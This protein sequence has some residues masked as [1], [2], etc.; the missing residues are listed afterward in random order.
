MKL[1]IL[2]S[3]VI[4]SALR[5]KHIP[6]EMITLSEHLPDQCQSSDQFGEH[7]S[8]GWASQDTRE[9]VLILDNNS[10]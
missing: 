7:S 2:I 5:N 9:T 6:F 4:V 3:I 10:S 8:L 1:G